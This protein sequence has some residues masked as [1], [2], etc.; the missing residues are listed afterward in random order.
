MTDRL[1]GADQAATG[2]RSI[3]Y[4]GSARV[5]DDNRPRG[6]FSTLV[7][8]DQCSVGA[9]PVERSVVKSASVGGNLRTGRRFPAEQQWFIRV[10]DRRLVAI[11]VDENQPALRPA[12]RIPATQITAASRADGYFMAASY[13]R[14]TRQVK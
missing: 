7:A 1:S 5:T 10:A 9:T 11:G 8:I 14:R 12:R 13:R 6:I 4:P 2:S 3:A